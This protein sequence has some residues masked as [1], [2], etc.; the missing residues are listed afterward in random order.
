MLKKI[1]Q[2]SL[3]ACPEQLSSLSE[4]DTARSTTDEGECGGVKTRIQL[5]ERRVATA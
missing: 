5:L 4:V 1:S 2:M 3:R